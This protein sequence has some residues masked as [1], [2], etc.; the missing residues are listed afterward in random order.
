MQQSRPGEFLSSRVIP[1]L[2]FDLVVF[3]ATGDLAQRKILPGLFRRF[4]VGQMP[5]IGRII[6]SARS[7]L[8]QQAFR[9]LVAE[10]QVKFA[11]EADQAPDQ[12]QAFLERLDYICV[13]AKGENGWDA[14]AATLRPDAVRAFYLS[15]DPGLFGPIAQQLRQFGIATSDSRIVV[16]KPFGHDLV[17]ARKLNA[18]LR[19]CFKEH[20]IYRIDHYLGKETV[21]NLMALRFANALFE[22]LWNSQH[23]D[24]VQITMAEDL[25]V[26][27]A[28]CLLRSIGRDA[29]YGAE[30]PDATAMPGR[31]GATV[32]V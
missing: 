32:A 8:S 25:G 30:S 23:I 9:T 10:A 19:L 29:R 13:D 18:E 6:G 22:P 31:D 26:D 24:H 14:L 2:A 16:E 17:T 3:G 15:V 5:Q 12:M 1:V 21:Q 7:D 27:G 11:A 20:Q 4:L 28:G